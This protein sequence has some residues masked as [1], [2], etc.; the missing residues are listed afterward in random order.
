MS[1]NIDILLGI[2]LVALVS[3]AMV[4]ALKKLVTKEYAFPYQ[5][6]LSLICAIMLCVLTKLDI[7]EGFGYVL[8]VPLIGSI[9]TGVIASL[10]AGA[11]YDLQ[12]Q[13]KEYRELIARDNSE[14]SQET[15]AGMFQDGVED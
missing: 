12:K 15:V 6:V 8:S 9:C 5:V 4:N 7:L 11:I 1:V 3:E 10:G 2:I 13:F 14:N